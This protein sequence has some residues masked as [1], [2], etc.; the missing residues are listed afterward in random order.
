MK[1]ALVGVLLVPMLFLH[2]CNALVSAVMYPRAGRFLRQ[3]DAEEVF[4]NSMTLVDDSP[5]KYHP[6]I[7]SCLYKG[8]ASNGTQVSLRLDLAYLDADR[9]ADV[10]KSWRYGKESV[11]PKELETLPGIGESAWIVPRDSGHML[12]VR[13]S[14]C[15]FVLTTEGISVHN[16]RAAR[17]ALVELSR[18]IAKSPATANG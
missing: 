1:P 10:E 5:D 16:E 2:G 9:I 13:L 15:Y 18:S 4:G 12:L 14:N 11:E 17:A 7:S 6:N 8:N 3:S